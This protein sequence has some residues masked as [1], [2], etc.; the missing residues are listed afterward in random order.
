MVVV[1]S[2]AIVTGRAMEQ[3]RKPQTETE[4]SNA[5]A[6]GSA[7]AF[8]AWQREFIIKDMSAGMVPVTNHEIVSREGAVLRQ[9][10]FRLMAADIVPIAN[11][12]D[13][14]SEEG[15][16]ELRIDTDND[17]LAGH[18]AELIEARHLILL[19]DRPGLQDHAKQV[20]QSVGTANLEEA[21]S[22]VQDTDK[23]GQ[24]GGMHSKIDVAYGFSHNGPASGFAHIAE[25][26]DDLQGV[27][28]G[29]TGTHFAPLG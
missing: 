13:V 7:E 28:A 21:R 12:N 9:S 16:E 4:D 17:R 27:I 10:L 25:A 19:T 8:L 20:V 24:R 18:I 14:L 3:E 11:G 22:F 6:V 2:G 23:G 26:M 15:S 1:A 5:A 29:Q